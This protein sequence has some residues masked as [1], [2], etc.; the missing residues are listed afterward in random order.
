MRRLTT[1]QLLAEQA[2]YQELIANGVDLEGRRL[3]EARLAEID[4][5]LARRNEHV[6]AAQRGNRWPHVDLVAL[7]REFGGTIARER[8]NGTMSGDHP[9]KHS[10]K[11]GTCLVLWPSEGR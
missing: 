1:E 6:S 7:Y 10:S 5:E 4:A 11:S 8:S 9:W 3:A 2:R